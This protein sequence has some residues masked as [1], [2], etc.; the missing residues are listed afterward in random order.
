MFCCGC[1]IVVEKMFGIEEVD[2]LDTIRRAK[3]SATNSADRDR[4]IKAVCFTPASFSQNFF[5]FFFFPSL[6]PS[7]SQGFSCDHLLCVCVAFE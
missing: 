4:F 6:S 3:D 5:F 7:C 1:S 2:I